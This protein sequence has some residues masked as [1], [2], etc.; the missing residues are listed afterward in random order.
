VRIVGVPVAVEQ[1]DLRVDGM[2]GH[3]GENSLFCAIRATPPAWDA[4]LGAYW[5]TF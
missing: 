5:N 2:V 1:A 4:A 3:A